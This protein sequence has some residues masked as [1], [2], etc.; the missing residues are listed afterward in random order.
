MRRDEQAA[1]TPWQL[2]HFVRVESDA[3]YETLGAHFDAQPPI[4]DVYVYQN[5]GPTF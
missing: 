3:D 4:E 1:G 2:K 5:N